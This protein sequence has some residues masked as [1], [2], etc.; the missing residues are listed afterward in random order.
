MSALMGH[1]LRQSNG[2][3]KPWLSGLRAAKPASAG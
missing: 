3:L 2:R 1:T